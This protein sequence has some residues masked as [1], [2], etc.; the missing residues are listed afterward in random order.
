MEYS[1]THDK[2]QMIFPV[3]G[4]VCAALASYSGWSDE[5]LQEECNVTGIVSLVSPPGFFVAFVVIIIVI[6]F[7][8]LCSDVISPIEGGVPDAR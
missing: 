4:P 5:F 2:R 8:R 7:G 1:N 3:K 6:I